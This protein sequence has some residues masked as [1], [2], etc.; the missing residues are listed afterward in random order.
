MKQA[1][2]KVVNIGSL[3]WVY[4]IFRY[5]NI[6]RP[7]KYPPPLQGYCRFCHVVQ[8]CETERDQ[9]VESKD[10]VTFFLFPT[11]D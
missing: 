4:T 10:G 2:L 3:S 8:L 7:R 9:N 6:L 5:L 1:R 11:S